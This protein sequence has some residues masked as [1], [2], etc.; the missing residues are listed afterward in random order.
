MA[1]VYRFD[2]FVL[3]AADRRL[4]DPGGTVEVSGRYLDA[5]VL[6]ITEEGR[7]V[8][9]AR[10]LDE[11]WKGVPVTDEAL[12]QCVRSLRKA[13]GDEAGRPRFIETVPRHGYRFIASVTPPHAERTD[14]D[15]ASAEVR[16]QTGRS[17]ALA[18]F[19]GMGRAG[20][21]GGGMAGLIGGLAYGFAG[22]ADAGAGG[23]LSGLLV[24]AALT[25]A[26]G[27]IGGSSVGF[28][29]GMASFVSRRREPWFLLGGACGGLVVGA[30]VR[31]A[32]LDAFTLLFGSA[33]RAMTGAGEGV[34]L[35]AAIGAGV[36]ITRGRKRR[37]AVLAGTLLTGFAGASAALLGGRLMGGSLAA[38]AAQFPEARLRFDHLG[39]LFGEATFGLVSQIATASLEGALFGAAMVLALTFEQRRAGLRD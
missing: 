26:I 5:L 6:L 23:S 17:E 35:G 34:L 30:V 39:V 16:A 36:W 9:K 28:G 24:L 19:V 18:R 13:L 4:S 7:L 22:V 15:A 29:V 31:L 33:P 21:I 32:G 8:T 27:M 1:G 11:V 12:T 10:L 25:A 3:D 2:R 37:I 20:L 38:L 14:S